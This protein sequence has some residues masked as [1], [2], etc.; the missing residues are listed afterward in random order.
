[1]NALWLW[2]VLSAAPAAPPPAIPA[3]ERWEALT[4]QA[5]EETLASLGD[6]P[7]PQRLLEVSR[8]FLDTPYQ[9]SP[10]GEGEGQLPDPDPLQRYDA[11]DCLTFV[12]ETLA[13]SLAG[14]AA[15]AAS[16]LRE[17]RYHQQATYEDRNHLMEVQWLPNN[18]A[19]RFVQD[20]TRTYGG[21]DVVTA[22]KVLTPGTWQSQSSRSLALPAP[23]Q[24]VGRF[25]FPLLP[26]D[27]VM[28]HAR[29]IPSG[30]LLLVVR[31]DLPQKA[32][33]ITHLGFVVQKKKRTYLRHAARNGYGRVVDEDL[34]TFLIRN[35]KYARW[36]VSGI[37]LFEVLPRDAPTVADSSPP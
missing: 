15:E 12:E 30:T 35:S 1:M 37:R 9:V 8:R 19:K 22:Q 21:P 25:R 33:R 26:I 28:K 11:V 29:A 10:L 32:T 27:K 2:I 17:I 6:Q 3:R 34:E 14:G 24:A 23:R 31:E 18:A 16:L 20:V 7:L 36:R 13:L 5:R 4:P